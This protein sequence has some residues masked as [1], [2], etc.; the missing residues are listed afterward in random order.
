MET[1][2]VELCSWAR[3]RLRHA[4]CCTGDVAGLH[5]WHAEHRRDAEAKLETRAFQAAY[6]RG[7]C[8]ELPYRREPGDGRGDLHA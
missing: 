1:Q 2:R 8:M 5:G 6:N 4:R 3:A 7:L